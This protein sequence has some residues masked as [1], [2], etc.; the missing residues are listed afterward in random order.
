MVYLVKIFPLLTDLSSRYLT[1][2]DKSMVY[3]TL[4]SSFVVEV[5]NVP[6]FAE[7]EVKTTKY[8]TLTPL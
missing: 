7:T 3:I 6:S 8:I 4:L 5:P 2:V 1:G